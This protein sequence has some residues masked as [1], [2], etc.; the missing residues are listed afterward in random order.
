MM[1]N[2]FKLK[3]SSLSVA[4]LSVLLSDMVYA[5]TNFTITPIPPLPTQNSITET[6]HASFVL[7]NSTRSARNGYRFVDLPSNVVQVV[8]GAHCKNT[9]NLQAGASCELELD[10]TGLISYPKITLCKGSS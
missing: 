3:Y 9:I 10:I 5:A 6:V 1:D 2:T 7:K 4:I 8:S